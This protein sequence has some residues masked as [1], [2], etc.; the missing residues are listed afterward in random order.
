MPRL[1][2]REGRWAASLFAV[3][4]GPESWPFSL[5]YFCLLMNLDSSRCSERIWA[6]SLCCY[7]AAEAE[8]KSTLH[9]SGLTSMF[10]W[11]VSEAVRACPTPAPFSPLAPAF[12][13]HFLD[14]LIPN[15]CIFSL[16]ETG[17][18]EGSGMEEMCFSDKI[19]AAACCLSCYGEG[20]GC[21]S[22][23]HAGRI[24]FADL[25]HANL[26]RFLVAHGLTVPFSPQ[27]V[28]IPSLVP[29][30]SHDI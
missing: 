25:H 1:V 21:T 27:D 9:S 14:S 11:S 28:F 2:G 30:S 8:G 3:A 4:L 22:P 10:S 20:S 26:E 13:I 15:N 18:L 5:S 19:R 7:C 6:F 29:V 12:Q 23:G 24:F 16:G 17:R